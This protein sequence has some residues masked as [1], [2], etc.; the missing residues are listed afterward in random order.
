MLRIKGYAW[1]L[2]QFIDEDKVKSISVQ[3]K[4]YTIKVMFFVAMA[5]PVF[6]EMGACF[7]DGKVGFWCCSRWKTRSRGC[8]EKKTKYKKCDI[9]TQDCNLNANMYKEMLVDLVL[10]RVQELQDIYI[11]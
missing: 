7:F 4:R 8:T 1:V 10:P 9:Y 11:V 6:D 2:P 3:R 5:K